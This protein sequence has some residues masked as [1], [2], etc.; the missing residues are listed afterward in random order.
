MRGSIRAALLIT[1]VAVLAVAVTTG[2]A[3][4]EGHHFGKLA[5]KSCAKERKALGRSLFAQTWGKPAMPNCIGVTKPEAREATNSAQK[6]CR[7]ERDELGV[8]AFRDKYGTNGKE[9]KNGHHKNAFGKCVSS[10]VKADLAEDRQDTINA[11]KECKA[12]RDDIGVQAFQDKYGTNG[13]E[14]K[15]GH[16]KN[17]FGKCVSLTAKAKHNPSTPTGPT[18]PTGPSGPTGPIS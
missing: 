18:G 12:E 13:K 10:H 11:A 6:D 9:G 8:D 14:G 17:A 7:A 3:G 16:H 15:N 5:A 2:G 1:G 4:A